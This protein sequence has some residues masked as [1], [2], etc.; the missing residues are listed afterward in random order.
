[1]KRLLFV[2]CDVIKGKYWKEGDLEG[3]DGWKVVT[4]MLL[5]A[6]DYE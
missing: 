6:G 2:A 5:E 1:M 4:E 3:K